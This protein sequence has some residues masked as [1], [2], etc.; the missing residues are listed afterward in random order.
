MMTTMVLVLKDHTDPAGPT[1]PT[2]MAG[3]GILSNK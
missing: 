1:R 3:S 2:A